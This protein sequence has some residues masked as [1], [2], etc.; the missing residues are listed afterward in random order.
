VLCF[1]SGFKAPHQSAPRGYF[2]FS[3]SLLHSLHLTSRSFFPFP[4]FLSISK[5]SP[6][7]RSSTSLLRQA[8][9]LIHGIGGSTRGTET[10]RRC[11]T[12][13]RAE[14]PRIC[15]RPVRI[16]EV[17]VVGSCTHTSANRCEC[18]TADPDG[19]LSCLSSSRPNLL[20]LRVFRRKSVRCCTTSSSPTVLAISPHSKA[21]YKSGPHK[22]PRSIARSAGH[23]H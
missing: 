21:S 11:S 2:S 22:T 5:R 6:T 3:T 20:T 14:V 9:L 16:A 8:R 17:L 1:P 23:S 12:V 4:Q 10:S 15:G 13:L 18:E 19:K 7:S